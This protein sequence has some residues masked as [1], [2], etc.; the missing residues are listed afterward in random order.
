M[1]GRP[2]IIVV[3]MHDQRNAKK[4][5]FFRLNVIHVN[6]H[7]GQNVPI[8]EKKRVLLDSIKGCLG[9]IFKNST[10]HVLQTRLFRGKFWGKIMQNSRLEGVF[11]ERGNRWSRMCTTLVFKWPP[12]AL[13]ERQS[14]LSFHPLMMENG[15]TENFGIQKCECWRSVL[16]F[17][18]ISECSTQRNHGTPVEVAW[19]VKGGVDLC[20]PGTDI[21]GRYQTP[22]TAPCNDVVSHGAQIGGLRV[23]TDHT[24]KSK[25]KTNALT[26][27]A[28]RVA[29]SV[30]LFSRSARSTCN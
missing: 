21:E 15:F 26:I 22:Y 8:F 27:F 4:G 6:R 30:W 23:F 29:F 25:R 5:C 19:S 3:H 11:L 14:T 12:R 13:S 16:N 10:K 24:R 9:V 1:G 18:Y 7:R 17:V 2:Q 28:R 20:T